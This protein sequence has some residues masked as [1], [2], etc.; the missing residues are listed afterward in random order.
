M[1]PV[2]STLHTKRLLKQ[3]LI[4]IAIAVY[5]PFNALIPLVGWHEEHL[6]CK[7]LEPVNC[8]CSSKL[9]WPLENRPVKQKPTAVYSIHNTSTKGD[10]KVCYITSSRRPSA[11]SSSLRISLSAEFVM[12][13]LEYCFLG[14]SFF[15]WSDW[16]PSVT[17]RPVQQ[18]KHICVCLNASS[19]NFAF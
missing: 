16:T 17:V 1:M 18:S 7:N 4:M 11:S 19:I 14:A 10:V 5:N 15:A 8:K 2:Q 9:V 3:Y 12:S 6:V 13:A